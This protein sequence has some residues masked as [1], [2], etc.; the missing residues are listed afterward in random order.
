[1]HIYKVNAPI[2]LK[3]W[4]VALVA[5][6][7]SILL[8]AAFMLLVP[9]SRLTSTIAFGGLIMLSCCQH[10]VLGYNTICR[11]FLI[12][13]VKEE[14]EDTRRPVM[15]E[16]EQPE[17]KK[18]EYKRTSE[19][20]LSAQGK[21]VSV[22]ITKKNFETYMREHKPYLNP[23]IKITDLIE[24]LKANRT[25]ISNFVN[26]TY[27]INFNRYINQLRLKETNRLLKIPSNANVKL[28]KLVTMA[29][30][31]DMRHYHRA[32]EMEQT[33]KTDDN[34]NGE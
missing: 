27:G 7:F 2:R 9:R 13:M 16:T 11:N 4:V 33:E 6:V 10:L 19:V 30:F 20:T 14:R 1:M 32:L 5:I 12:Y 24:P 21:L 3:Y 18:R 26:T 29:G 34:N 28:S 22:P 31:T 23:K 17:A 8:F 15:E 25:A